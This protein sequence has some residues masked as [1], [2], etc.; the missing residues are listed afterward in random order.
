MKKLIALLLALM[1]AF[2]L[3]ACNKV[4]DGKDAAA[5][6]EAAVNK[7]DEAKKT[8]DN[9]FKALQDLDVDA[10]KDTVVDPDA[11]KLNF[12]GMTVDEMAAA[13]PLV[14]ELSA[15]EAEY[16][17]VLA[18]FI[19]AFKAKIEYKIGDTKEKD[20]TVVVSAEVF[21]PDFNAADVRNILEEG[22]SSENYTAILEELAASGKIS[23]SSTQEEIWD[24]AVPIALGEIEDEFKN[25]NFKGETEKLE[26]IV[27][28]K[29]GKWLIDYEKSDL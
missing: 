9:F 28:E 26:I 17:D 18:V 29:D 8:V 4:E 25:F 22:F 24:A 7:E 19:D 14:D 3:V 11:V 10:V 12:D 27:V 13:M 1:C 16:K 2:S 15:Y 5:N 20:D 6:S 23:E 21:L